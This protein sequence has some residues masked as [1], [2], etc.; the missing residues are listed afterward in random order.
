MTTPQSNGGGQINQS[1]VANDG[2]T[3]V[4][5]TY[6]GIWVS[7]NNARSWSLAPGSPARGPLGVAEG[8]DTFQQPDGTIYAGFAHGGIF[9]SKD[10]KIM[11]IT[12]RSW[13]IRRETTRV[14]I[15]GRW[16]QLPPVLWRGI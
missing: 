1:V 2:K 9:Y 14:E 4:S 11:D 8:I 13:D 6:S 15:S 3:I 7:T 5:A 16:P 12:S 10:I